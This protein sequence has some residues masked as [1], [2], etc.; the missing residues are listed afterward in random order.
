MTFF[1]RLPT[2]HLY[3]TTAGWLW[4]IVGGLMV[5]LGIAKNINLLT[6]L[7]MALVALLLLNAATAGRRLGRARLHPE[8][9]DLQRAGLRVPR[10]PTRA[11]GV[12]GRRGRNG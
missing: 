7:G 10:S 11:P 6:L 3:L 5:G 9:F 2:R 8:R 1:L 12:G 4:L